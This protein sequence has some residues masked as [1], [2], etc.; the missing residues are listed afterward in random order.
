MVRAQ[1]APARHGPRRHLPLE[2]PIAAPRRSGSRIR[3]ITGPAIAASSLS[4]ISTVAGC[5]PDG[6]PVINAILRI[7]ARQSHR[8]QLGIQGRSPPSG[9][10][11]L[12]GTFPPSPLSRR[13]GLDLPP[14]RNGP[15]S[16]SRPSGPAVTEAA[17]HGRGSG[18]SKT[19]PIR[20]G[21]AP[22]AR[23]PSRRRGCAPRAR[24]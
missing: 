16:A 1:C 5:A 9:S 11:Q 13:E 4:A 12:A 7:Q 20:S 24:P 19:A 14:A 6:Y 18:P 10:G 17:S 21:D 15:G 8:R 22:G 2:R 3:T 23:A